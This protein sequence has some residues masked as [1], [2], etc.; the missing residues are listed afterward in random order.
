M[1]EEEAVGWNEH[2]RGAAWARQTSCWLQK[3]S[4][5]YNTI[6]EHCVCCM[7]MEYTHSAQKWF[8]DTQKSDQHAI[9]AD[10]PS[11]AAH[12]CWT[13][14]KTNGESKMQNFQH[15]KLSYKY[16][17]Y[18]T[19]GGKVWSSPINAPPPCSRLGTRFPPHL[20]PNASYIH[21]VVLCGGS[22]RAISLRF[23]CNHLLHLFSIKIRTSYIIQWKFGMAW[24][25]L[26]FV[27]FSLSRSLSLSLWVLKTSFAANQQNLLE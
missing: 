20:T 22:A 15:I 3:A 9:L 21:S 23:A 25:G 18:N 2:R 1:G 16:L 6:R 24:P 5:I 19:F 10:R 12:W 7:A 17:M 27:C 14:A 4:S 11:S 13:R 26:S 8:T